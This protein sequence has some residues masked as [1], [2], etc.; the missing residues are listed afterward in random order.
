[1]RAVIINY[2][3]KLG[4][5]IAKLFIGLV[6]LWMIF[7]LSFQVYMV[8]LEFS[9]KVE[10]TR[11]IVDWFNV[12]LH[13][14]WSNDPRNIWYQEPKKI[15][16]SSVTNKVVVGSLA[17]NRNLEFGIKNI[18]EE[19]VQ[20]KEYELDKGSNL[21]L[22]V[23][24]I[25]LDVLKTQSS[26]SVLHNNKESVV[27]RLRGLLYKDGKLEKKIMVEESADEV[28]MS[29]ILIDEG[30]KFNQTNLSSALKKA[31]SSLVNKLL[32]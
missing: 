21:K 5:F 14:S 20:E 15:D 17:G 32:N 9:G 3:N 31:S 29:A 13:G 12:H 22:A 25:Y 28:S 2:S 27:I 26:F 6:C 1:M 16:I 24:I 18:L 19:A 30:G 23:E 7:A 8:Y 11:S 10:T 4:D